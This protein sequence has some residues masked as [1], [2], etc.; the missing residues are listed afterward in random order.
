ML[1]VEVQLNLVYP[2]KYFS[3]PL[4]RL[5]LSCH[6]TAAN[7][8]GIITHLIGNKYD[9]HS[10]FGGVVQASKLMAIFCFYFLSKKYWCY[11]VKLVLCYN[12][13]LI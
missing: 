10:T 7:K 3:V 1:F 9:H 4:K 13:Y 2:S 11:V 6:Q 12:S 8:C 5:T